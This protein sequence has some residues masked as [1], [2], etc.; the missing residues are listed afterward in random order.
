LVGI[1]EEILYPQI[2]GVTL[3]RSPNSMIAY[4]CFLFIQEATRGQKPS[5]FEVY[6]ED[7]KGPDPNNSNQ[8]CSQTTTDRLVSFDSKL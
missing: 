7:H 8:L 6:K 5:D 3:C 2:Q 1:R 4:E